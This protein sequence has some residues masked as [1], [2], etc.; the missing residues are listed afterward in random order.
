MIVYNQDLNAHNLLTDF[1]NT[2]NYSSIVILCGNN[3]KKYCLDILH[4]EIDIDQDIVH[5]IEKA[6]AR[7]LE[8]QVK[9][10]RKMMGIM[11]MANVRANLLKDRGLAS[12]VRDTLEN[13]KT[14]GEIKEY[15][16]SCEAF[17]KM[18]GDMQMTEAMLDEF[19]RSSPEA[20]G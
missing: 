14:Q 15:Y 11:G 4:D 19:I 12:D 17:R 6:F 8:E 1:I 10:V 5:F 9:I 7:P 3:T 18:W 2:N 16:W 20:T 13:G